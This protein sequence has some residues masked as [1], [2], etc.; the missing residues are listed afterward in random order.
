VSAELPGY[1]RYVRYARSVAAAA[2][3]LELLENAEDVYWGVA[4]ALEALPRGGR[5]A[6]VLEIGSGLGYLTYALRQFGYDARGLDI[7]SSA[8]AAARARFGDLFTQADVADYAAAEPAR[9][10]AVVA[11]ELIEHLPDPMPFLERAFALLRPGGLLVLTTPNRSFYEPGVVWDTEPPPVHFWWFG[12]RSIAL[13]GERLG[14]TTTFID[15]TAFQTIQPL[16]LPD[17]P[18]NITTRAPMF[19]SNFELTG[20][21]RRSRRRARIADV[22]PIIR[23]PRAQ[24]LRGKQVVTGRRR[25]VL[26]AAIIKSSTDHRTSA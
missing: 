26:C 6:R 7:S 2:K 1:F 13:A 10:D 21:A 14:G 23:G 22:V 3:P 9:F 18:A 11:C 4:R 16:Y 20:E 17:T 8:V 19:E 24:R 15:F 5:Q 25:P 12:E